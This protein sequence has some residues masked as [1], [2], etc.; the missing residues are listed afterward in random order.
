M[1]QSS[2][3]HTTEYV[4]LAVGAYLVYNWYTSSQSTAAAPVSTT[5]VAPVQVQPVGPAVPAPGT[6]TGYVPPAPVSA[7]AA[8]VGKFSLAGPVTPNINNSLTA[9]VNVNGTITNVSIIQ[10]TGH[11][12]NTAGVDVTA[13]LT[14]QGVN[15]PQ[16]L[17]MMQAA[18]ALNPSGTTGMSGWFN[19]MGQVVRRHAGVVPMAR[20]YVRPGA[21]MRRVR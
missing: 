9:D 15:V 7:P 11:A 6:T 8:P 5:P 18:Y 14:A 2:G 12:Y 3:G 10:T 21:P 13:Q 20:N 17:T 1:A 4:L 19:G 16:L